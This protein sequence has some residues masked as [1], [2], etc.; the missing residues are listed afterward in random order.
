MVCLGSVE[1]SPRRKVDPSD[2]QHIQ[3]QG[4]FLGKPEEFLCLVHS[5]GLGVQVLVQMQIPI[6]KKDYQGKDI[7]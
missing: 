1:Q 6:T 5:F 7:L 4:Q 3:N 2:Q